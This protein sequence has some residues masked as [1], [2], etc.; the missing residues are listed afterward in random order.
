LK[1]VHRHLREI[2]KLGR[3]YVEA[4]QIAR[5]LPDVDAGVI[6]TAALTSQAVKDFI[7]NTYGGSVVALG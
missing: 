1:R 4:A 2:E 5:A 6:N 7:K 3:E